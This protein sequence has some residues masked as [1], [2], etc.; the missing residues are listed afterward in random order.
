MKKHTLLILALSGTAT[1]S[2][3]AQET[4]AVPPLPPVPVA[5]QAPPVPSNRHQSRSFLGVEVG[6][7]PAALGEQLNLPEG[8]GVLVEYV[9]PG[10]A[11]EV[12]GVK[13]NDIL[14]TVDGQIVTS[15]EHLAVLVRSF[16]EGQEVTL[17]VLHKGQETRLTAKLQK[18][19]GRGADQDGPGKRHAGGDSFDGNFQFDFDDPSSD[20]Q[21]QLRTSLERSREQVNAA[22]RRA[23]DE[24][25]RALDE[26][27]EQTARAFASRTDF[28]Q[29]RVVLR[30][31]TGRVELR[32]V[33]GKRT[34]RVRDEKGETVFEGPINTPEQRRAIPA[35]ALPK[36]EALEREQATVFPKDSEDNDEDNDRRDD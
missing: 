35:D 4:P 10:S 21:R 25:R 19:A 13:A 11:A 1:W 24:S 33:R 17:V 27:R 8:F 3:A 34:L 15:A 31:P 28:G 30:D 7:L 32:V 29:A 22:T 20:Y 16:S 36:V 14:K 26:A 18:R 6:H 23:M 9:V 12:A 2:L 5:P